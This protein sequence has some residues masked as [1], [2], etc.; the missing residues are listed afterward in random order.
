MNKRCFVF[1]ENVKCHLLVELLGRQCSILLMVFTLGMRKMSV[2][3]A[4]LKNIS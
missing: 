3:V 2:K 4:E 1:Y